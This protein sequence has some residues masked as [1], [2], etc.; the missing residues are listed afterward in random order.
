MKKTLTIILLLTAFA[1][2]AEGNF[3]KRIK[4]KVT[5]PQFTCP[6]MGGPI[7]KKLYYD[8]KGYRIYVC[9]QGCLNNPCL[10]R[11]SPKNLI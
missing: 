9:C 3:F 8:Y 7:N 11:N 2:L 5:K 4:D 6:V 1:A 10:P